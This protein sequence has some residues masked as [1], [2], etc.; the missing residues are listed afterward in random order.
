MRKVC[1]FTSVHS[2]DD[3][4]IVQKECRSLAKAGWEVHLVASGD[5]PEDVNGVTH[6]PLP[7][8]KHK[9]RAGRMLYRAYEAYRTAKTIGAGVY[10]FHDPELLPYGYLLK[11]QGKKVIYDAHEDLPRDILSKPWI[12]GWLRR[13]VSMIA[14]CVENFV[15]RR[16]DTV[17]CATPTIRDRFRVINKTS[18]D[19][20]NFPIPGELFSVS[21]WSDKQNQVCYIGGI[22]EIRGI[23]EVVRAMELTNKT[24][25]L[26]LGGRFSDPVLYQEVSALEGWPCVDELGFLGRDS[27]REVMSRSIAGI[28]TFYRLPNH[29]EAQPNKLFEYMSAAIPVIASDFPLWREIMEGNDCGLCVD[30]MK[31]EA[32]AEAIDFLMNHPER[33]KQMGENGRK[34]VQERF[35]WLVEERKLLSLYDSLL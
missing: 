22:A 18:T 28:V 11:R 24:M 9:T 4:R 10:H 17:V 13:T 8:S 1:H 3:I 26:Q 27:V 12:A 25:R 19:I 6:H 16:L 20:N 7:L 34:A 23:K 2:A 5:L 35:N 31:P 33:A 29:I 32:I 15:S 21:E 30:P 14:E